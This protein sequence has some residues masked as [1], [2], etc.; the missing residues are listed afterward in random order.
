MISARVFLPPVH[1]TSFIRIWLMTSQN[2][3]NLPHKKITFSATAGGLL[4][5]A[6]T[7]GLIGV[8]YNQWGEKAHLSLRKKEEILSERFSSTQQENPSRLASIQSK[9][10]EDKQNGALWFTLGNEYMHL[11][12]FKHA[13][14]VYEY[15]QRLSNQPDAGI[16][17]AQATARYYANKQGIDYQTQIWI[18]KALTLEPNNITVFMLLATDHFLH[19]RHQKAIK[20]WVKILDAHDPS[21]DRVSLIHAI[22]QAKGMI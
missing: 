13:S 4:I 7:L 8:F 19:A 11:S 2:K 1:S 9:V 15:A 3:A 5:F 16:Y 14:Q 10:K 18:D 6:F 12:E 22:S 17:A 20:Y 21:T